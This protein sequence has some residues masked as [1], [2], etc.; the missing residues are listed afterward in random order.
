MFLETLPLNT[1]LA[2]LAFHIAGAWGCRAVSRRRWEQ[3]DWLVFRPLRLPF[4]GM[5][6]RS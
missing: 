4:Q 1:A 6:E 2:V 5:R 3:I